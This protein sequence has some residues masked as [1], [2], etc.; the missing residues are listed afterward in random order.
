MFSQFL[1]N[2]LDQ[3]LIRRVCAAVKTAQV[4]VPTPAKES[5]PPPCL[6]DGINTDR[7]TIDTCV[8]QALLVKTKNII[9]FV[10]VYM[11]PWDKC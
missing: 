5:F 4:E 11:Q 8:C 1:L 10:M 6:E 7:S 3:L 9:P 2:Y